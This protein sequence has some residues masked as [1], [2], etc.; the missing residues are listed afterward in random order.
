MVHP[1]NNA[2]LKRGGYEMKIVKN[3]TYC[4]FSANMLPPPSQQTVHVSIVTK[5]CYDTRLSNVS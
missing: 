2:A 5:T 4:G 1:F 3:D